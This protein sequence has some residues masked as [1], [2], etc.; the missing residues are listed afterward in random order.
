[1][2]GLVAV[3]FS[4]AP[5][6][7]STS[8]PLAVFYEYYRDL[9]SGNAAAAWNLLVPGEALSRSKWIALEQAARGE[10]IYVHGTVAA[11]TGTTA[12]IND[13][14]VE[15]PDGVNLNDTG[16]CMYSNQQATMEKIG[17]RWLYFGATGSMAGHF[18]SDPAC[19][20]PP[21]GTAAPA[22]PAHPATEYV[23]DFNGN[24]LAV[25]VAIFADPATP[26]NQFE[27][28]PSGSRLVAIKEGVID[29]GPGGINS[30]ADSDTSVVGSNGQVYT[31]SVDDVRGCTNFDY[32][33]FTL[34]RGESENGCVAFAIPNGVSVRRVVFSLTDGSVDTAQWPA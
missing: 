26:A 8:G 16:G 25:S 12:T 33:A 1:V 7:S 34:T 19:T 23:H 22:P 24:K 30:D 9:N 15:K 27:H 29:D 17:G 21:S 18:R 6:S 3:A 32:G 10:E 5:A 20:H 4:A 28:A 14:I 13:V 11:Q 2:V 31:P